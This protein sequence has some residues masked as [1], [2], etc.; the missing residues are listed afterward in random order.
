MRFN[1][2]TLLLCSTLCCYF[3]NNTLQ[4]QAFQPCVMGLSEA[5]GQAGDTIEV[6]H[7]TVSGFSSIVGFQ[8]GIN[9][10]PTQLELL[11][12]THIFPELVISNFQT[13]AGTLRLVWAT[14]I[15]IPLTIPDETSIFV[16]KFRVLADTGAVCI[17][18]SGLGFDIP[19]IPAIER[20][21][22]SNLWLDGVHVGTCL[23]GGQPITSGQDNMLAAHELP[24]ISP[25]P[26]N[27]FCTLDWPE[28]TE[29]ATLRVWSSDGREILTTQYPTLPAQLPT[30]DWGA[31]LYFWQ[32][33]DSKGRQSSG[34]LVKD[35]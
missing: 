24:R 16:M 12:A 28:H 13:P 29:A 20:F 5:E 26:C 30:A 23:N 7:K 19:V 1:F 35:R 25:N 21:D 14:S 4:A 11:S 3:S 32:I 31:G 8:Y 6:F 17:Q 33:S 34:R 27:D 15:S 22:G 9:W 10:D 2:S 18:V